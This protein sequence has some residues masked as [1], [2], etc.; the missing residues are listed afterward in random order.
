MVYS[1]PPEI[2]STIVDYLPCSDQLQVSQVS[3][4]L[5]AV[6]RRIIYRN[7]ELRSDKHAARAT[8]ALLTRDHSVARN[9]KQL[10]IY[11][12]EKAAKGGT[13]FN[14]DALAGMVNLWGLDLTR[15]PFHTKEDQVKFNNAISKS[16][17]A[18]RKLEYGTPYS[19]K[20]KPRRQGPGTNILDLQIS[21]LQEITWIDPGA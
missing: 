14:A 15:M 3:P 19:T 4:Q 21:G 1:L 16:L 17:P 2:W 5:C 12:A 8:L 6:A 18:L 13:W 11:T 9:I 10:R 20:R 7:L